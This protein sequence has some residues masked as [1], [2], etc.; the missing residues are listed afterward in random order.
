MTTLAW[1]PHSQNYGAWSSIQSLILSKPQMDWLCLQSLTYLCLS[2][3][4]YE[5]ESNIATLYGVASSW[6]L[7]TSHFTVIAS[8]GTGI[9]SHRGMGIGCYLGI[10]P[11]C[12]CSCGVIPMSTLA[13]G[14]DSLKFGHFPTDGGRGWVAQNLIMAPCTR[15]FFRSLGREDDKARKTHAAKVYQRSSRFSVLLGV[16]LFRV[17]AIN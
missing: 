14:Y 16:L 12:C 6:I 7:I 1:G 13:R 15:G 17:T 11:L 2:R 4:G 3:G 9:S 10:L 8:D 5:L